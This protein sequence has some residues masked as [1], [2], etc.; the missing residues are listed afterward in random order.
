MEPPVA[1]PIFYGECVN[2]KY[3]QQQ[4]QLFIK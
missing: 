1:F 3:L 2:L 4:F